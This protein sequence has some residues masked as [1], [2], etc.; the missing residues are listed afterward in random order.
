MGIS[1]WRRLALTPVQAVLTLVL[2]AE[3]SLVLGAALVPAARFWLWVSGRTAGWGACRL[4]ALCAA[5]AAAWFIF[6]TALLFVLPAARWLTGAVGTPPGTYPFLSLRAYRWASFNALT[7]ILRFSFIHWIR[8][9]PLLCLYHRMMGMRI[10]ARVQL[11]T[12]VIADQ[13][14]ISIGDDT[15]IGGDVTLVAH[16]AE[17]GR[18]FAA[19]VRIGRHVTVGLM[20]TILPGCDIGDGA[21]LCA[22]SVL[23]KGARVGPGEIWAGVPARKVGRRHGF[24]GRKQVE[25]QVPQLTH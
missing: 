9:T 25:E 19:P 23:A 11:N 24:G 22:G 17:K 1:G 8:L 4:P 5:T 10:G 18:L 20:S 16:V 12:A 21:I 15:V 2:F 7:L 13:N 14:L 3:A 6:G